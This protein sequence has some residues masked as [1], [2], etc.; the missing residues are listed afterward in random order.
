M[1][2]WS[3]ERFRAIGIASAVLAAGMVAG[4]EALQAAH[5][6]LWAHLPLMVIDLSL[7]SVSAGVTGVAFAEY[8]GRLVAD[9]Q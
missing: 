4:L 5:L 9:G 6:P 1:V 7:L 3:A 2:N 8:R